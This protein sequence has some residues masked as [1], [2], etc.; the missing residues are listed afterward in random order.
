MLTFAVVCASNINRSM[1]IHKKLKDNK[2]NV[3]S[4]GTNKNVK[5][6]SL[7]E[8]PFVFSFLN[9]Y[10]AMLKYIEKKNDKNNK[11]YNSLIEL[12]N[13]NSIIKKYPNRFQD[14]FKKD[15]ENVDIIISCDINCY[16]KIVKYILL[17][18]EIKEDIKD[19]SINL[20]EF[21]IKKK[22]NK[23]KIDNIDSFNRKYVY[24]VNFNIKDSV[25]EA[26]KAIDQV[27]DFCKRTI[28]CKEYNNVVKTIENKYNIEI[29]SCYLYRMNK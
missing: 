18:G 26:L 8:K 28:N 5:L 17:N 7:E 11:L 24:I 21:E 2:I 13:N 25:E 16:D 10:N 23:Y 12:L 1:A 4:Y 20:D 3:L 6:P 29:Q 19:L 9:S 14:D 27:Y 15:S 22:V